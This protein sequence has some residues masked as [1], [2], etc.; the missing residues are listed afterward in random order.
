MLIKTRYN[1]IPRHAYVD[2]SFS[3]END[4][5][6]HYEA[7][8][9]AAQALW[10]NKDIF[11]QNE[12]K[13]PIIM[14]NFAAETIYEQEHLAKSISLDDWN[15]VVILDKLK[16]IYEISFVPALWDGKIYS[17]PYLEFVYVVDKEQVYESHI[18]YNFQIDQ[19]DENTIKALSKSFDY[20]CQNKDYDMSFTQ[21][22]PNNWYYCITY[23]NKKP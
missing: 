11:Y 21:I 17:L 18:I 1:N 22:E 19:P 7:F 16:K 13:H 8:Q 14:G 4:F 5:Y 12:Q 3:L 10:M 9:A 15:T 6:P 23:Y 2:D 20:I